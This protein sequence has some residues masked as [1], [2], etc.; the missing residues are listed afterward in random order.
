MLDLDEKI[1]GKITSKEIIGSEPSEVE[2]EN[3]L[4]K[5]LNQ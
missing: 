1:F 2:I 5:E 4:T 3:L